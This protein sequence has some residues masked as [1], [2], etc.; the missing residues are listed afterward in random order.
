MRAVTFC[1][2]SLLAAIAACN[3]YSPDLGDAPFKCGT[4]DPV[5]PDGYECVEYSASDKVCE[6]IGTENP[7]D[8][9]AGGNNNVD[10]ND[11]SS[12]EPNDTTAN[13]TLTPI[14][15]FDTDVSFVQLAICPSTDKDLF[16]FRVD[17]A[18]QQNVK[19]TVTT[20][21]AQGQ[22]LVSILNGSGQTIVNGAPI[23]NTQIVASMNDLSTGVWYVQVAAPEGVENNYAL[24]IVTCTG[25]PCP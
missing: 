7:D 9:D 14:P 17:V 2:V 22:L 15:D 12:I 23:S 11:D 25:A 13:A 3:P 16:R 5:C 8:P 1:S 24:D 18:D 6:R 21:V 10:C 4:D 19:A 20:Q